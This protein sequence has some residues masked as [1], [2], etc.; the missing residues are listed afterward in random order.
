MNDML[1]KMIEWENGE[2]DES[3]YYEL[4]QHLV[5]TGLAWSL[6]GCYGREAQVMLREGLIEATTPEAVRWMS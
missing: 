5:D 3:G 1:S 6:Q 2:L 4:F